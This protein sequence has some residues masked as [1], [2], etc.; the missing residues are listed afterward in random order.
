ML[1]VPDAARFAVALLP[2]A[3]KKG[4]VH[5]TLIA[6]NAA[7]MHEFLSRSAV[8]DEGTVAY[9]LPALLEALS[10]RA[11]QPSTEAIVRTLTHRLWFSF[12]I[13]SPKAWHLHPPWGS[14]PKMSPSSQG[15]Q[16][17]RRGYGGLREPR[18]DGAVYHS[19]I[20]AL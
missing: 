2:T 7:C 15:A 19:P 18:G 9:V 11:E 3:L 8:L 5:R 10:Q 13:A 14:V 6:F 17:Y 20:V 16:S 4:Y 1:R 12:N